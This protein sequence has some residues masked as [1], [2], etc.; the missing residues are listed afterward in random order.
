MH[1]LHPHAD[2]PKALSAFS[3]IFHITD[4]IENARPWIVLSMSATA[5]R[6]DM[7]H[8]IDLNSKRKKNQNRVIK[9]Q[10]H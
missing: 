4:R 5:I 3:I 8:P 6:P 1:R 7:E 9:E 2:H 10:E